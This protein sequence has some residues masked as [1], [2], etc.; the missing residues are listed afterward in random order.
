MP[1]KQRVRC[2]REHQFE[3]LEIDPDLFTID[4]WDEGDAEVRKGLIVV[5]W[6]DYPDDTFSYRANE[7]G[8]LIEFVR[9]SKSGE[10]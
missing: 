5:S 2:L 1:D 3:S 8:D 4:R 6:D 10:V 9:D 7:L